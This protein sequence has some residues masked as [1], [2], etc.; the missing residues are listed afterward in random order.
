[1]LKL[2]TAPVTKISEEGGVDRTQTYDILKSLVEK[3]LASYVLARN[4]KQFSPANPDQILH[5]LQE[6]EKEF[7]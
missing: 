4:T 7:S 2:K 3:G 5:D 6:K 1:M